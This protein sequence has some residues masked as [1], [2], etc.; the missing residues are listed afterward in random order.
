[1]EQAFGSAA[2]FDEHTKGLYAANDAFVHFIY[3]GDEADSANDFFGA[4]HT[5]GVDTADLYAA[6]VAHL[7]DGDGG[8]GLSLNTL[9]D[10]T[11]GSDDAANEVLRNLKTH[12]FRSVGLQ[13][14]TWLRHGLEHFAED[15]CA[16]FAGLVQ[17]LLHDFEAEALNF[18]VHL[19]RSNAVGSTRYLEVHVA[20]V[21]FVT[22]DVAQYGELARF[23]VGDEAHGNSAH[24]TGDGNACVHE[25]KGS[26]TYRSH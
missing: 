16:A 17:G 4:L 15:V 23:G 2:D 19:A 10:F 22:Q 6:H 20:E 25:G 26:G 8:S 18:D 1:M 24:R 3:L 5:H 9:N 11:A 12:H 7:F 14:N 21:V 13:F